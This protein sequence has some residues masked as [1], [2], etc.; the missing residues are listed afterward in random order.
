MF[1]IAESPLNPQILWAGSNDGL[2]HVT[3]DGGGS[4]TNV[5]IN[6][7][8]LPQ[9]GTVS[10]IEPSRFA[11]GSAYLTVDFHQVN[12]RAPYVY[13]TKDFG[14]SW[15]RITDNIPL[16]MLSYAH[17]VKEDPE[18]AGMLYLGTENTVYLSFDDGDHWL[19]L[20]N[21]LPPAPVH[22]LTVQERFG[23]LVLG[24][25]GRGFWILDD[26]SPLRQLTGNVLA[27]D[28]HLFGPRAAYR[29]LRRN[30]PGERVRGGPSSYREDPPY[31]ASINY[32]LA[33]DADAATLS[34]RDE[35]GEMVR[36]FR[37]SAHAG[38]NRAYWDLRHEESP[39]I[40]LRT[41]PLGPKQAYQLL[42]RSIDS[43]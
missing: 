2:I 19:L 28:V 41:P 40:K 15:V 26:L 42:G 17:V 16:G 12:D 34:I 33:T 31:G 23:D 25:Y 30:L 6:I 18:R 37:G 14:A 35:K 27:S 9:W 29:L 3:R 38:I 10:N 22:W 4:W 21:N 24:T 39:P 5:T 20:R 13:R 11:A 43:F 7:E 1:A 32:Y 8:G 36:V